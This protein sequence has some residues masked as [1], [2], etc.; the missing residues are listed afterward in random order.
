MVVM[1]HVD[2]GKSTLLDFIRKTNTVAK[3]AGGITQ[4][5]AAY[6]VER[7]KGGAIKHITF[8]DTPGHAA[9]KAIRARGAHVADI[10][11]LVVAADDGVKAQT[12]EALESIRDA[13]IPF[14]VAINKI[15][16]SNAS[17]ERTH[18]SLLEH[19]IYLEKFGGDIPWVAISAK[20][21]TGIEELLDLI[22]TVSEM[23]ELKADPA[24]DASGVVIEAHRDQKRGIAATLIIT[25]GTLQG[26]MAVLAG[27][28]ISPV[29]IME[30]FAGKTIREA[31]FS[32]PVLLTGFDEMPDAG[33]TFR[34]FTNKRDAE[35][36][37]PAFARPKPAATWQ[38]PAAAATTKQAASEEVGEQ[39]A[40][41]IIVRADTL[42]S[43]E[44]IE[45]EAARIGDEHAKIAIVQSGI[46]NISENDVKAAISS[47]IPTTIVGFNVG[48]DSI[49]YD[50]ARQSAVR[51]ETF[52]IIYKLT[53]HLEELLK[54]S[55]PKRVVEEVVGRAKILKQFS[56]RKDEHVIGGKVLEGYLARGYQVHVTRRNTLLGVGKIRNLQAN[57][58][59]VDR[60]EEGR[61]FGAQIISDFEI[62]H[63]DVVECFVATTK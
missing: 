62:V 39:F 22:L 18:A 34:A 10:A 11:I 61:E 16:K 35:E 17:I 12:L 30:N 6:E 50:H 51:I 58:Q 27:H 1:G 53:E 15:D 13:K 52:N 5:V 3:E 44:A 49:A 32:S 25:N 19:Q 36:V 33:D 57:K 63:G 46:G 60:V 43:L 4:H 2:H 54:A 31:T 40:M 59:N 55:A 37:R 41:P 47:V 26:G 8:I 21:G 38:R 14:I 45:L 56:S 48:T 24:A 20:A 29:R 23:Q 28:A 7:E 9:F 42:G